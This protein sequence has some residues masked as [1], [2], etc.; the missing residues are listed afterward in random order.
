LVAEP[1]GCPEALAAALVRFIRA[2]VVIVDRD[3]RIVLVNPAMERFTGRPAA[4]LVGRLFFDVYV[5]PE[6]VALAQDALSRAMATG[7]AH[8]QEGDWLAAGGRRR[9]IAMQI[10][11]LADDAGRPWGL[12]CVGLDVTEQRQQEALLHRRSQTDLLTG[13]ANRAA[14]FDRLRRHLDPQD[15]GGCGVL[16]CDL[17]R[18]KDVNDRHGH[19]V[20]DQLLI[21]AAARLESLTGP[22]DMVARL[23]GDEF[24]LVCPDGDESRLEVLARA[25]VERFREPFAGPSSDLVVGVSVGTAVGRPGQTPDDL[26]GRADQSMYSAKSRHRR[27]RPRD[28]GGGRVISR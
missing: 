24:V 26:V 5:V 14:L 4:D 27:H 7:L 3:G 25:A 17:D 23:G 2:L 13:V 16:F 15:G 18:F 28:P 8:P 20:G 12:A 9:R 22:D 11:V 19:G 21:D 10:D 6:H 1:P